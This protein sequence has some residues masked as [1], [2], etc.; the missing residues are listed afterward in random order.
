MEWERNGALHEGEAGD[1][2][3]GFRR[4]RE[5]EH[6]RLRHGVGGGRPGRHQDL[7]NPGRRSLRYVPTLLI[8]TCFFPLPHSATLGDR[9]SLVDVQETL[10]GLVMRS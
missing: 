6:G 9:T 10:L 8:L 4:C 2:P 7:P 3:G 1:L 5:G